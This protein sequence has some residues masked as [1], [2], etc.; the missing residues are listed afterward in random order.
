[1]T[2]L[3]ATIALALL[4]SITAVNAAPPNWTLYTGAQTRGCIDAAHEAISLNEPLMSTPQGAI[5]LAKN[6]GLNPISEIGRFNDGSIAYIWLQIT[7]S[8]GHT[9]YLWYFPNP[10]ICHKF[11]TGQL[12]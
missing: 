10:E 1:M 11:V 6:T 4:G 9:A 2:R 8:L 3:F 5:G 12:P 7:N